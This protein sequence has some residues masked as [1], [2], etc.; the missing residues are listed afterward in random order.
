[1]VDC[2]K[3][4][5]L[6]NGYYYLTNH[7]IGG[8]VLY[9][10]LQGYTIE[11]SFVRKCEQNGWSDELPLCTGKGITLKYLLI[12]DYDNI[13]SETK[14]IIPVFHNTEGRIWGRGHQARP[15]PCICTCP[16]FS[17]PHICPYVNCCFKSVHNIDV[18]LFCGVCNCV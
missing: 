12:A 5:N 4:D 8:I 17:E 15:P 6:T 18:G 16:N 9:I 11:G 1:M 2:G 14:V 3:P 13:M 10:C 7:T